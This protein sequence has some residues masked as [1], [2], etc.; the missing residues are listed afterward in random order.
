MSD[1]HPFVRRG[2]GHDGVVVG[3]AT[4]A[5]DLDEV[6]EQQAGEFEHAR[7]R[8]VPGHQHALPRRE[9]AVD[10]G[11][12]RLGAAAQAVN[13]ALALGRRGQH[14]QRLDLLQEH[15]D[16]F[17]E[18]E[19]IWHLILVV[20]RYPLSVIR[21]HAGAARRAVAALEAAHPTIDMPSLHDAGSGGTASTVKAQ[22]TVNG[23][24][25]TDNGN[26]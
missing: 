13:A 3:K 26:G 17:F 20:I 5:V 15:A 18:L 8:R 4:V 1:R 14:R 23:Q 25:T 6:G 11:A 16:R 22:R 19:K 9:V 10:V 12:D 2:A 24:R 7:P 21:R